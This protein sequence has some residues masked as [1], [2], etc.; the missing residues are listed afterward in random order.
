MLRNSIVTPSLE[1]AIL[2]GK[3][4]NAIPLYCMEQEF[5]RNGINISQAN[6]ANWTIR[7]GE[8]YFSLIYD[9]LHHELLKCNVCQ[10]DE[11]PVEV[12][13]DGREAG[14]KSYMWVYRT[15][16][17][18][19]ANPIVLYDYQKNRNA[20]RPETFLEGYKGALVSD[21]YAI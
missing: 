4:V 16:K 19:E 1:S 7:C 18:Y 12:S 14:S 10:A 9:H 8:R 11:T 21:G 5:K 6:M 15:G 3:Y 20:T 2:N 13:K 17:M